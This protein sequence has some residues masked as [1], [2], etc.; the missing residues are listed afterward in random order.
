MDLAYET[1]D[2]AAGS[3]EAC[4]TQLFYFVRLL[5]EL[6]SNVVPTYHKEALAT[7]PQMAGELNNVL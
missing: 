4:A 7:L 3:S 2:E 6:F 1:L 5:F